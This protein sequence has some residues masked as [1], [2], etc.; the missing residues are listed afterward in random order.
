[1]S[2]FFTQVK[3]SLFDAPP[4]VKTDEVSGGPN[5]NLSSPTNAGSELP[6]TAKTLGDGHVA[7]SHQHTSVGNGGTSLDTR[8]GGK[9]SSPIKNTPYGLITRTQK[10][11]YHNDIPT[12][13]IPPNSGHMVH[14]IDQTY[15]SKT[16]F[17]SPR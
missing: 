10:I 11:P 3:R 2:E 17:M 4:T 16:K 13:K 6:A 9:G 8:V 12:P 15:N 5:Q 1:M 14:N 7:S